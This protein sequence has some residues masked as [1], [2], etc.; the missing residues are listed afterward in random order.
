MW[1]I[2]SSDLFTVNALNS[3]ILTIIEVD[4]MLIRS[5]FLVVNISTHK[6]TRFEPTIARIHLSSKLIS[7]SRLASIDTASQ[8]FNSSKE[9]FKSKPK[10]RRIRHTSQRIR[11][12]HNWRRSNRTIHRNH[13]SRVACRC[14]RSQTHP[15]HTKSVIAPPNPRSVRDVRTQLPRCANGRHG[16]VLLGSS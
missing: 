3:S 15:A 16:L 14:E 1:F 6:Q 4:F 2:E 13:E 12:H 11:N 5:A 10:Q 9:R 7:Q 8:K